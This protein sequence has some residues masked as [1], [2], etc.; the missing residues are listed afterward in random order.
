MVELKKA[1]EQMSCGKASDGDGFPAEVCNALSDE[2]HQAFPSVLTSIWEEEEMP[3]DLGDATI[4]ALYM[5]KG[6]RTDCGNY[7]GI[8]LLSVAGQILL[9]PAP[10]SFPQSP[11]ITIDGTQLKNIDTFKYLGSTISSDDTMV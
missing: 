10:D 9:L 7:Q 1:V 5:N 4:V 11:C 2:A 6:A 3:T 8:S